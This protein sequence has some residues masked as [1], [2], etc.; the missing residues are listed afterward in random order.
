[1]T[2]TGSGKW[3]GGHWAHAPERDRA[4]HQEAYTGDVFQNKRG[5]GNKAEQAYAH[6]RGSD[7]LKLRFLLTLTLWQ[8]L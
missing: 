5:A 1:M 2:F 7:A 3:T 8:A 6:D 4:R